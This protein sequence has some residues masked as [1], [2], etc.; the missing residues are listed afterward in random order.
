MVPDYNSHFH[1]LNY[2]LLNVIIK[3]NSDLIISKNYIIKNLILYNLKILYYLDCLNLFL[4]FINIFLNY[5]QYWDYLQLFN[6]IFIF[7]K[8]MNPLIHPNLL[9]FINHLISFNQ[10]LKNLNHPNLYLTNLN[11]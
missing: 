4:I 8:F 1:S 10:N 6:L 7:E 3:I 11:F 2:I 9:N 5:F